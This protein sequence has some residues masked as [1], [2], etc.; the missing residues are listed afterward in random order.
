M[1]SI[2]V[3][4]VRL[5]PAPFRQ[6]FGAD[7]VEQIREDYD[8][9]ASRGRAIALRFA[10]AT[11]F[12]L[13]RCALAERFEPAW[14]GERPRRSR[15]EGKVWP[16]TGWTKDLRHAM[17][18]LGRSPGIAVVM[19]GTL[20]LAM[21][22]S[23]GIF[24]VVETVL[25]DPLPY[26]DADRLVYI[27]ASAPGSDMPEEFGVSTEFAVQYGEASE[28]L[29]SVSTYNSF[30]ATLRVGDRAERVRMSL[31]MASLFR[32]LGAT[33]M[34][35][36]LP[37]P[38]DEDRVAVISH[39]L[40]TTWFASDSAVIGRA[41]DMIGT[42]RTVIGVMG[43]EFGF[44]SDEGQ[45]LLW[46]PAVIRPE[47]IVPGRF[48]APLV[49]R[50]APGVTRD[51]L[52][53][54]LS[55]LA[56]R[57]PERFGGSAAYARLI[58]QHRPIVRPLKEELVGH[59]SGA[60][61]ILF[62]SVG[63]VLLIACANVANLFMVRAERRQRE[64]A[65]RRAIGAARGRL[66][67]SQMAEAVVVAVLAGAVA[68]VL[69][70]VGLPAFIRAAPPNVP[71][72]GEAGI[73]IPTLAF[74]LGLSVVTALLCGLVPALRA[75]VPNLTR[76]RDGSRGST[77]A[78]RWSRDG[79]VVAQTA[80]ALVLL[81]GSGLLI[82][83]FDQLR[84][85]D[86][87]YDTEDIFTFQIAPEGSDLTDGPSFAR[88]HM[89]F[90]DR[91]AALPG[92]ES[93]GLVENVPLNEGLAGTRFVTDKTAADPE[94]A[95]LLSFTWAA[96]D[97]FAT[98]GIDVLAGRA[99][100]RADHVSNPGNVV[101]S[102]TA[103]D[104][105]WPGQDPIGRRLRHSDLDTWDSVVGVVE[106]VM[107]DDFRDA[108]QPLVYFPLVGPTPTSWSIQSPAYVVKTSRAE[109]IAPEIR[110]LAQEVR[111]EAPM[112]RTFTMAGLA[113]ASM[114]GLSF[115]ALTL[116]VTA[117][118]ALILGTVGLYGVLSYVVAE[119]TREIGVR[120]A[121]G[122]EAG[123]VRRMVVG[124]GARVVGLGVAIGLLIAAASTRALDSLLFGVPAADV[125]T[126]VAMSATM[127][128]VGLLA[129]YVPARRASSVD[130]LESLRG[131]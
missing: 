25:L 56:S 45:V 62:G 21:G 80:L 7:M 36:R 63:I 26:P 118:L 88:F 79:L 76:L 20:G 89:D 77:R 10:L 40:W 23:A 83:S 66:F 108:P 81:I 131:E 12:D 14:A 90:M 121:L 47:Q 13:V 42:S 19:V 112:Y 11:A 58:E 34:L 94:S 117:V 71:R 101:I 91:V 24:S 31:P 8:G 64:L 33:P 93:V 32:T 55:A 120:M 96:G 78:R 18:A 75:S 100:T 105:L 22:A 86:P 116:G 6:Q 124:Q 98:M 57:L 107:Q 29:E 104:L 103:A 125:A 127:L 41:Y 106:D 97:Y 15:F 61:W 74:T 27:A 17:R 111:P 51:A 115:T 1:K 38:E 119:R 92:V 72:L 110:A 28:L 68:V 60:L 99:F 109:Q 82:R 30:T 126:F 113:A 59:V 48:G 46:I 114:V 102:R 49:G 73:T 128:F 85:V 54:E 16:M 39:A 129:S 122:A 95:P 9:A 2:L 35:G 70:W 84:N 4:L 5:F 69:A 53:R 44:P 50:M 123:R 37:A 87:G 65:I 43:P 130:P 67:R 52:V 3:R